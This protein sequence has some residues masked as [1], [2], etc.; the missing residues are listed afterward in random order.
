MDLSFTAARKIFPRRRRSL[1]ADL[2]ALGTFLRAMYPRDTVSNVAADVEVT[3][4]TVANWLDGSSSPRLDHFLRLVDAY[5]P[6]V[7]K[8][9][10]PGAPSWLDDAVVAERNRELDAEIERLRA[11]REGR[12]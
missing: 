10:Y 12:V 7:I 5:G 1:Q 9:A 2:A 6:A 3:T 11:L 4:R 8:A